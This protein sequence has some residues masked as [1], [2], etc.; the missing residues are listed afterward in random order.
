MD[1]DT[2]ELKNK[3]TGVMSNTSIIWKMVI[4]TK[5]F[6]KMSSVFQKMPDLNVAHKNVKGNNEKYKCEKIW[7]YACKGKRN[8]YIHTVNI[9]TKHE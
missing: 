6:N 3:S 9:E 7:I 1:T 8:L 4:I 5:F 2:A